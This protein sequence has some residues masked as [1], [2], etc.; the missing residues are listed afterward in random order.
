VY[1]MIEFNTALKPFFINYLFNKGYEKVIYLDPDIYVYNR[2]DVALEKLENHSAIV[3]PHQLSPV[4]RLNNYVPY[5]QWEQSALQTGIFN[6]GF[7]G[8]SNSV[9]GRAF[10]DWWSN[11]CRY[12]CFMEWQ[13]G[14]FFDQKWVDMAIAYFPSIHILRHEGY[15]TAVWNIHSR[16]I[17]DE[18]GKVI[19]GKVPLV[20]YHFSSIDIFN[21]DL[22]SK[23]DRSL[24]LT[25]RPDLC[26]LFRLYREK[27]TNNAYTYFS[28]LPYAFG[29]FSD[30]NVIEVVE[31]RFYITIADKDNNPFNYTRKSFYIALHNSNKLGLFSRNDESQGM[32]KHILKRSLWVIFLLIGPNRYTYMLRYLQ[33]MDVPRSHIILF[34]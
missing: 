29:K 21:K 12:M 26:E 24:M 6:L 16:V 19:N 8:V 20:F 1:D 32:I 9:E 15:N 23:H 3:T 31:R 4:A 18:G 10:I 7:I 30:G 11:R 22:I 28:T 5:I 17:S 13:S 14:L 27:V 2:L 34:K 33:G 25:S